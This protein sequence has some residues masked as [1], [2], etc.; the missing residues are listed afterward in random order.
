[1]AVATL[2]V[3][4]V[5]KMAR[6]ES[7]L[8][9]ASR[10]TESNAQR[11]STAFNFVK[12]AIIGMA[13]ALSV[14]AFANSVK[15]VAAYADEI[16]KMAQRVGVGTEALSGL[17]YAAK[18]SDVSN[19]QLG[20]GLKKLSK[21]MQ[22]AAGGMDQ[23]QR[24]LK[25]LGVT[26]LQDVNKAFLQLAK[27]FSEMEEGSGKTAAA[28][29]VFGKAGADLLP[30]LNSGADGIRSATDEA[31][32]F[33][34]IVGR[35]AVVAAERFNDNLERLS[36]LAQGARISLL[37][38]LVQGL[39]LATQAYLDAAA[40][41]S[42]FQGVLAGLRVFL[43]GDDQYKND[44][45]LT[46]QTEKLLSL[47]KEISTLRSSGSALDAALARRKEE[48][49]KGLQAEIKTTLAF[50][51]VL[52]VETKP[53]A[54][55]KVNASIFNSAL[56][57][58]GK[59]ARIKVDRELDLSNKA[60]AQYVESLESAIQRT[61][62]LSAE[63][64]ALIF[65]RKKGAGV[66]IDDAERVI[67][68][69]KQI[70]QIKAINEAEAEGIRLG[71]EASAEA[72]AQDR[73]RESANQ[74]RIDRLLAPTATNQLQEQR[75]DMLFLTDLFEKNVIMEKQYLEAVSA[76][77]GITNEKM[78]K[79]KSIAEELGLTFT[80]AFE[81]AIVGGKKFSDILKGLEQDI[82]RIV[83]R[84]LVTEPLAGAVGGIVKGI[85]GGGG[86]G[87]FFKS[88]FGFDGGGYTGNGAR[89]GGLDG[90]GGFMAMMHPRETVID[91]TKGQ[92]APGRS[93]NITINPPA[94]M[95]RQSSGQFAADV[96]RQLR[97]AD[98]RNG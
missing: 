31:E 88:I 74:S 94:G 50:R 28:I 87:G 7:D 98:A 36:T 12:G 17:A 35:D 62:D 65:L 8:S 73:A 75:A 32:R 33:G 67:N 78:E 46:E 70:D 96:A 82:L 86:L 22:E 55:G 49:L 71:R 34:I 83:T 93:M 58:S 1:M 6:F 18:L 68:L 40:A 44:K 25:E 24:I 3:D 72:E 39:G 92:S 64:E 47:E 51:K 59:V 42:K 61:Q 4:L 56:P 29:A 66:S 19:E 89:S 85:G 27:R 15:E 54:T 53:A 9:R 30:L 52:E 69:A 60:I 76:R 23:Q 90:K 80:S 5:A 11:M 37:S 57:K 26:E 63:E 97:M 10:A 77:L 2:S 91:H 16:G 95:S 20:N 48:Q 43:T 41:G 14:G 81:D 38:D 45:A 21:L 84:K 79:T 13:G